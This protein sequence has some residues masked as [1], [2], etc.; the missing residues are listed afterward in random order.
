MNYPL[1]VG[2]NQWVIMYHEKFVFKVS[3]LR[4]SHW[5]IARCDPRKPKGLFAQDHYLWFCETVNYE[6]VRFHPGYSSDTAILVFIWTVLLRYLPECRV[7]VLLR[8]G[9]DPGHKVWDVI[10]ECL[11][12]LTWYARCLLT[13]EGWCNVNLKLWLNWRKSYFTT[14]LL[15]YNLKM[16][17]IT[18]KRSWLELD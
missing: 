6:S 9:Y 10:R 15:L 4:G 5:V 14:G 18:L 17:S 2:I 1:C 12:V 16:V 13:I 8:L 7:L 3:Q 11:F